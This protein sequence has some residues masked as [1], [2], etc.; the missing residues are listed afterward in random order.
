MEDPGGNDKAITL[1]A[2]IAFTGYLFLNPL[3]LFISAG[4]ANWGMAWAYFSVSV[5]GTIAS[6]VI[7][8]RRNP[9][10]L[11]ERARYREVENVKTW[12]KVLVPIAALLGPVAAIIVAG[13]DMRYGWTDLIPLWG[14]ILGLLVGIFG[15]GIAAWAMVENRFFSAV[16]RIQ[17]DRGHTVC[18]TGPYRF[19]RHPG[20]AG[21]ILF[22]LITPIVFNAMW[23]YI[24]L[25]IS[26]VVSV[27]RT[28]LEDRT[29]QK[30]LTGYIEYAE[31]TRY[32]LMPGIW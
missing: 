24:P 29:L 5:F 3:I 28:A 17:E 23:A 6:R 4:T 16:V 20:Y 30:E 27:L 25:G 22:Y 32:R 8:N 21:G 26:I 9:G 13:L 19:I 18:D 2:I 1:R 11:E 14:Q 12:D 10:L 31:K 7:A 15:F